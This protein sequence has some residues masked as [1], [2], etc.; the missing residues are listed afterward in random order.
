M[1]SGTQVDLDWASG[2]G[3]QGGA[4]AT[5]AAPPAGAGDR[6]A[7]L[8]D[9]E[10]LG[11]E[12][13][14]SMGRADGTAARLNGESGGGDGSVGGANDARVAEKPQTEVRASPISYIMYTTVC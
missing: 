13:A 8:T 4:A 3:G 14:S 1:N 5:L 9:E 6:E 11:I 10:I 7:Y 12:P 2:D